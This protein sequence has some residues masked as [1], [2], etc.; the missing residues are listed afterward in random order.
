MP[1]VI[2][3]L[4]QVLGPETL[5]IAILGLVC[6]LVLTLCVVEGL[7]RH[8]LQKEEEGEE[9]KEE[10]EKEVGGRKVSRISVVGQ[11]E[12][13]VGGGK[14]VGDGKS[15]HHRLSTSGG[16]AGFTLTRASAAFKEAGWVGGKKAVQGPGAT[17]V[18]YGSV[19]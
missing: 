4:M 8:S 15:Y 1:L 14:E 5:P 10:E 18:S 12:E 17:H 13:E 9:E 19:C 7:G 3:G 6:T 2:G 16:A 11:E